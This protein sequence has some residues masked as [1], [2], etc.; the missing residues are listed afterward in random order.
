[1]PLILLALL[2]MVCRAYGRS[3]HP[4]RGTRIAVLCT[5]TVTAL[6]YV[7]GLCVMYMFKF[8]EYE[9]V[10][11]ASFER[12]F[13]ILL[14]MLWETVMLM[15]VVLA[16]RADRRRR[17]VLLCAV[18]AVTAVLLPYL[19][20][21][22]FISRENVAYSRRTIQPYY[23]ICENIKAHM[24]DVG[25]KVFLVCEGS[26][27]WERLV[28][29][30]ELRP[31]TLSDKSGSIGKPFYDGDIWTREVSPEKWFDELI[32][33]NCAYVQLFTINEYFVDTY[34]GLFENHEV[35][36]YTLYRV[37]AERHVLVKCF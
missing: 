28:M 7:L 16:G 24:T 27:G 23:Q 36:E 12:Y 18:F 29:H 15:T 11:L 3:C 1:M 9:G 2:V 10:R 6:V 25:E 37:E 33:D 21:Y 31:Y 5:V 32:G 34:G 8:S 20:L 19:Q 30:Y 14:C 4:G 17:L 26:S 35:D 13:R 22:L